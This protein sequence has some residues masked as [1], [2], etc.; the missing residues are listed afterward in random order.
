MPVLDDLDA[1]LQRAAGSAPDPD[2]ALAA[3]RRRLDRPAHRSQRLLVAAIV[4]VVFGSALV[5]ARIGA[6]DA[7]SVRSGASSTVAGPTSTLTLATAP[8]TTTTTMVMDPPP[9]YLPVAD[10]DG[11]F[12]GYVKDDP[13][14][15]PMS[16]FALGSGAPLAGERVI[17]NDGNQVGYMIVGLGFVSDQQASDQAEIDRLVAEHDALQLEAR[18]HLGPTTIPSVPG[19]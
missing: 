3:V 13:D 18:E 12:R 11:V 14:L 10:H 15:L 19:G 5:A 16:T 17:D 2:E 9:G 8:A 1:R 7:G 6:Q 4:I